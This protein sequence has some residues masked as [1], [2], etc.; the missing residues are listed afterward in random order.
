MEFSALTYLP[1]LV[2]LALVH[3][4]AVVSPG[5][6]FALT[7]RHSLV[8]S[9]QAGLMTAFGITIGVMVH[10]F[11]TMLGLGYWIQSTAWL[12]EIMKL[13]GALYIFYVGINAF[14]FSS[15][16]PPT[17]VAANG[18]ISL[19]SAFTSGFITNLLN[20]K[21]MIFFISIF[22][23]IVDKSTP[24]LIMALYGFEIMAITLAWFSCVAFIFSHQRLRQKFM[25]YTPW[26]EKGMGFIL[27]GFAVKIFIFDL[28]F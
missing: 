5:P 13:L 28:N 3:F 11:Y 27:M 16:T 26:I 22:T 18:R 8:F 20:P 9:K 10:V 21:A 12:L 6:D 25:S 17:M 1:S 24:G 23:M 15:K 4:V 7:V 19:A 2:T 14:L